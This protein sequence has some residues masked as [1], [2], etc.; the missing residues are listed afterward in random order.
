[1]KCKDCDNWSVIE[2]SPEN[3]ICLKE[4]KLNNHILI[5]KKNADCIIEKIVKDAENE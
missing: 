4:R 2:G 5:I 1:M 3:G